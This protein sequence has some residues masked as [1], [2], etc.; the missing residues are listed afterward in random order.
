MA[1]CIMELDRIYE[2]K[3]GNNQ[4]KEDSDI[5]GKLTQKDLGGQLGIDGTQSNW[6]QCH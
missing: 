4:H 2:I 6:G 1:K 3:K 5:V